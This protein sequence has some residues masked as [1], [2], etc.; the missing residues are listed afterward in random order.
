MPFS[1]RPPENG[2]MV[3][4]EQFPMAKPSFLH[5]QRWLKMLS[6]ILSTS[7]LACQVVFYPTEP[8]SPSFRQSRIQYV[9]GGG[10]STIFIFF[11]IAIFQAPFAPFAPIRNLYNRGG[12]QK[13]CST[14]L[15]YVLKIDQW[16]AGPHDYLLV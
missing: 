12:T 4:S 14:Y 10:I 1:R 2:A 13:E 8:S 16:K 11:K 6:S 5:R 9:W 3:L 15:K 7:A